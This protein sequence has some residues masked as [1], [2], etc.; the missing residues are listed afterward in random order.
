MMAGNITDMKLGEVL[1]NCADREVEKIEYKQL[2]KYGRLYIAPELAKRN[3]VVI[4][5][6]PIAGDKENFVKVGRDS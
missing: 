2:D 3:F 1:P 5:L 4:L 6:P